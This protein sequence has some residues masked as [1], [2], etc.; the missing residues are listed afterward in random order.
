[1]DSRKVRLEK[2]EKLDKQRALKWRQEIQRIENKPF[3]VSFVLDEEAILRERW[4][5]MHDQVIASA[6]YW[7]LVRALTPD[8][9]REYGVKIVK[10]NSIPNQFREY[11]KNKLKNRLKTRQSLKNTKF[12][13]IRQSYVTNDGKVYIFFDLMG[14][15]TFLHKNLK[16][17]PNESREI[18][19]K[20][21]AKTIA[22]GLSFLHNMGI[23][24]GH[25]LN[26]ENLV[27]DNR[28]ALKLFGLDWFHSCYTTSGVKSLCELSDSSSQYLPPEAIKSKHEEICCDIFRFGVIIYYLLTDSFPFT[29]SQDSKS[30]E[31]QIVSK[32]WDNGKVTNTQC[33]HLLNTI[34]VV[35]PVMRSTIDEILQN[36]WFKI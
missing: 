6:E 10:I 13:N 15:K 9:A 17:Y 12:F 18:K 28:D 36:Q 32:T 25:N 26:L 14:H 3:D 8:D 5:I 23:A 2:Q 7:T 31:Q 34:F 16:N 20:M 21:W 29:E 33:K 11:Y 30:L 4:Q 24:F 27:V 35:D 22:E 19:T 1:M